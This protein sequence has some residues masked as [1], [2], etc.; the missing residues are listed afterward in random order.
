MD[1]LVP[2]PARGRTFSSRCSIRLADM[3]ARGRLRLDAVARYLQ[4][5]ASDDVDETGWGSPDHRWVIR[6]IRIDVVVPF[7]EDRELELTTWCSGL[8]AVAAGRRWSLVGNRGGKIEAD[9]V[10]IH[11]GRDGKPARLDQGFGL[12]TE[13]AAG[14]RISTRLELPDPPRG[15]QRTLWPLRVSDIDLAG[16]VNNAAYWHAVEQRLPRATLDP[17]RPLRGLL[18]YRRPIDLDDEVD[19]V[20]FSDDGRFALAFVTQRLAKAVASLEHLG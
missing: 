8:A 17:R 20:E 15:G 12:Y 14:R 2:I 13:A 7:L 4:D 6:R 5:V 18:D 11:L 10:W 1:A 19:L 16:H 3:D 9:S